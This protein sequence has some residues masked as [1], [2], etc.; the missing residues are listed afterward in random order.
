V[1]APSGEQHEIRSGGYRAVVTECG[2]GLRVLE[3]DGRPLV[4]GYD[5]AS[6]A[7]A[8]RGQL[9]LPWPNRL[10]DGSY[11][12]GGRDHQLPLS[13]PSRH[14]ASHGL[15]RWASWTVEETTGHSVSL[16]YRLMSQPGYPWTVD[17]HVLYD[18]SAD[19][20]TA[21]I[22][23]SNMSTEP[24]PY[25]QGAHPYLTVGT[26]PVDGWEL[27]LP[28]ATRLLTN[29]RMLPVADEPVEGTPY[30]FRVRRPIRDL[31]LDDAFTD[32]S[33]DAE[34]RDQVE[35]FDPASGA[36]V[37]LWMDAAHGWVQVYS[38]D[39][40]PVAARASLAV[41]PMT[42]PANAFRSGRGLVVL[43]SAGSEDDTHSSSWGIFTR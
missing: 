14:N 16:V 32:V 24:A 12:F 13:E 10:E 43:G 42:A 20:L 29:D 30:D 1:V 26:G 9:L 34:G 38:G 28:A 37:G 23:A 27:R 31:A 3:Y 35:L 4:H 17:L 39:D 40:L 5:E 22:T 8:G 2:A 11:S 33:R 18:L 25:A 15:T 19:G 36:G 6:I 7:S 41:E 21:T